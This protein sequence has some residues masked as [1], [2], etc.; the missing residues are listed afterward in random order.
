MQLELS[1]SYCGD[2]IC[3]GFDLRGYIPYVVFV[4]FT[5]QEVK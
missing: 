3:N 1:S 5:L 4:Q 2:H